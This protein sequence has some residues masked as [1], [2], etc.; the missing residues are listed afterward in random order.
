MEQVKIISFII[1]IRTNWTIIKNKTV[2]LLRALRELRAHAVA[3]VALA[4]SQHQLRRRSLGRFFEY[5]VSN[6]VKNLI[7][8]IVFVFSWICA[9]C[10]LTCCR[11]VNVTI[12]CLYC[13]FIELFRFFRKLSKLHH[14]HSVCLFVLSF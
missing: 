11:F 8:I 14:H 5:V 3:R 13:I 4:S 2:Y 7:I 12:Y 10:H 6:L 1:E 9:C